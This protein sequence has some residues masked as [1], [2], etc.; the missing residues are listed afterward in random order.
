MKIKGSSGRKQKGSSNKKKMSG[1][2]R[3]FSKLLKSSGK[4]QFP[5]SSTNIIQTVN[6]IP[7]QQQMGIS[8]SN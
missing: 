3:T 7:N 4:K 2:K 5:T 1:L 8:R 6:N